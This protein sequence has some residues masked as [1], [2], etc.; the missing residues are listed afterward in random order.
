MIYQIISV[1]MCFA[2]SLKCFICHIIIWQL[3][4]NFNLGKILHNFNVDFIKETN[5]G[6]LSRNFF[7]FYEF[8]ILKFQSLEKICLPVPTSKVSKNSFH[9]SKLQKKTSS[10]N[11]LNI[12]IYFQKRLS[13]YHATQ[14]PSHTPKKEITQAERNFYW[15]TKLCKNTFLFNSEI[16]SKFVV[17]ENSS[18]LIGKKD[19]F[20]L[21]LFSC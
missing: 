21:L 1:L 4:K 3:I 10:K 13:S 7:K 2:H 19:N 16:F 15:H 8:E 18:K 9:D 12:Q 17:L 11:C 14:K 5:S 20:F 6:I